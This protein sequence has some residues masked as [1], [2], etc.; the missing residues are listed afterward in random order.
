MVEMPRQT[1]KHL[2]AFPLGVKDW[3]EQKNFGLC[4]PLG[5]MEWFAL[6]CLEAVSPPWTTVVSAIQWDKLPPVWLSDWK[7]MR[8]AQMCGP[9]I[10]TITEP[11][12][13][14]SKPSWG[15]WINDIVTPNRVI[16]AFLLHRVTSL[17]AIFSV[18]RWKPGEKTACF[19]TGGKQSILLRQVHL[20]FGSQ[21]CLLW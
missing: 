10:L 15:P 3:P 5:G 20:N 16:H 7:R 12:V 19:L 17:S 13:R 4:N 21:N 8:P 11:T 6:D 9:A 2:D 1:R 18:N 14:S